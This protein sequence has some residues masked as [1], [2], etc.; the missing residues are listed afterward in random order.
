MKLMIFS[1]DQKPLEFNV[2]TYKV[3]GEALRQAHVYGD[4]FWATFK[5]DG[6]VE[7]T[8]QVDEFDAF[9]YMEKKEQT[10]FC[11]KCNLESEVE[12]VGGADAQSVLDDI[13]DKHHMRQYRCAIKYGS[14]FIRVRSEDCTAGEWD[15]IMGRVK[16]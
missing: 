12:Y 14:T 5:K 8:G 10:F 15:R 7:H 13:A 9:E 11:E 3:V 6:T 16:A 4:A 2:S 1:A